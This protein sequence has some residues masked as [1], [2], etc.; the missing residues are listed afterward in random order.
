MSPWVGLAGDAAPRGDPAGLLRAGAVVVS[1]AGLPAEARVLLDLP[2]GLVTGQRRQSDF[3]PMEEAVPVGISLLGGRDL[4]LVLRHRRGRQVVHH[5]LPGAL[6]PGAG[7]LELIWSWS[8]AGVEAAA[9]RWRL[10]L[11]D[12]ATGNRLAMAQG[13]DALALDGGA[14]W[15]L[16]RPG[17]AR[18]AHPV[19]GAVAVRRAS[20]GP[21][22]EDLALGPAV[23]A[24]AMIATPKGL[25]P[26]GMLRAGD[27]VLDL[28]GAVCFLAA[29]HLA[30][31]PPGLA[32]SPLR[33]RAGRLPIPR[34]MLAGP[35][36]PLAFAGD[37][38]AGLHGGSR[39]LVAARH[40]PE[41]LRPAL[42]HQLRS[43]LMA[44]PVPET[45]AILCPGGLALACA[46][47]SGALPAG[48][49]PLGQSGA[50]ALMAESGAAWQ[51]AAAGGAIRRRT[52]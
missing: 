42:D 20:V 32:G 38:V 29:L 11:R 8:G 48:W 34:D 12:G 36:A 2:A 49:M 23:S 3:W 46:D 27:P 5:A 39:A 28:E 16:C 40:L 19:L 52:A 18:V 1:L 45:P 33:L 37:L 35:A 9:G 15:A 14:A 25:R 7:P 6:A 22:P 21:A 41:V 17:P 4:G 50:T 51:V 47:P 30:D 44:V 31:L 13:R 10:V 43:V 26:V 24:S